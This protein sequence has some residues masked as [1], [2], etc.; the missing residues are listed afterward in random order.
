MKKTRTI[1]MR[2]DCVYYRG[3]HVDYP[4]YSIRNYFGLPH[5]GKVKIAVKEKG[6]YRF[7]HKTPDTFYRIKEGS[8]NVGA[9]CCEEFERLFFKPDG[10]K[11]YDIIVKRV[12][13]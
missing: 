4:T 6:P 9:I 5:N 1:E 3:V 13:K 11:S 12:K 2:G 10:R 8:T 7:V